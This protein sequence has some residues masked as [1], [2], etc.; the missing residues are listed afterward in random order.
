V[1]RKVSKA[2]SSYARSANSEVPASPPLPPPD[3]PELEEDPE[4]PLEEALGASSVAAS[5]EEL[6]L[7][8][9]PQ[10]G[11]HAKYGTVRV[12]VRAK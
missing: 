10:A 8:E 9:L 2:Q 4:P 1:P 3:D 6:L 7:D 12:V 5:A 11:R